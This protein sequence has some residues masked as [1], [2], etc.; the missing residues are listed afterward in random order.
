MAR[1]LILEEWA[2]VTK[3]ELREYIM[4]L[5]EKSEYEVI[6]GS[7]MCDIF[8]AS[9]KLFSIFYELLDNYQED[10]EIQEQPRYLTLKEIQQRPRYLILEE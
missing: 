3:K 4:C 6:Y 10:E 1:D 5:E 2:D 9:S 7:C 8:R